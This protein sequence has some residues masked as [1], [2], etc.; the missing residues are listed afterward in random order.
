MIL[1]RLL[2]RLAAAL[3]EEGRPDHPPRAVRTSSAPLSDVERVAIATGV[4]TQR[5]PAWADTTPLGVHRR[6]A[7]ELAE[8]HALQADAEG[9]E[10]AHH[11]L[12]LVSA[13]S[14]THIPDVLALEATA[15]LTAEETSR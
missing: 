10:I 12:L 9:M 11:D 1:R 5:G 2:R 13:K 7:H 6:L 4:M 3:V 15:Y 8:I 14:G